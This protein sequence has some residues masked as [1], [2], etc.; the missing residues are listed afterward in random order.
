MTERRRAYFC[1]QGLLAAVLLLLFSYQ[2]GSADWNIQFWLLASALTASLIYIRLASPAVL[3]GRYAATALFFGDAVLASLALRWTTS[4]SDIYLIY[5]V[6]IFGTALARSLAQSLAV[7]FFTSFLY[8]LS[9][10]TPA[11]WFPHETQFW[12]KFIF[13]WIS[14]LILAVLAQDSQNSHEESKRLYERRII[15][16]EHLANL[17][18]IAGE[19]AHRIKG[20]LTTIM[21]NAE[22]LARDPALNRKNQKDLK[23]IVSEAEHCKEILRN[24]LDLGRIEEIHLIP[25]DLRESIEKAWQA[26]RRAAKGLDI[27]WEARGLENPLWILGDESLLQ[28]AVAAVLQNAVEAAS[29]RGRIS[30]TV[31]N[32]AGTIARAHL[33]G[34]NWAIIID[35]NGLGMDKEN[36]EKIFRPFF[37]TK[38]PTGHGLGLSAALRI[39]QKHGG[40][41]AASSPG[42]GL[43]TRFTLG[44]PKAAPPKS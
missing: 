14:A 25:L 20:P 22:L 31:K 11:C 15:Q 13:L 2:K 29:P 32:H 19:V 39:L 33:A 9:A 27:K 36:L 26:T 38:A 41:I 42:L 43:G 1:F 3:F 44:I 12:L 10:W 21:V 8:W 17:G 37:T 23:E 28:E 40:F 16:A 6:V 4:A 35:D 7:A 30:L 18:Q 5:L 24:L 34:A